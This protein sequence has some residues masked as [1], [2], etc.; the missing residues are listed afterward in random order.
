M[1]YLKSFKIF[2]EAG[3]KPS[4]RFPTDPAVHWNYLIGILKESGIDPYED[5]G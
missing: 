2:E 1:K 5:L 4:K 3:V